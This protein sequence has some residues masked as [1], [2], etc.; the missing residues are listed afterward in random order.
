[1]VV[2]GESSAVQI[3]GAV[4]CCGW[5]GAA[6]RDHWIVGVRLRFYRRW[7]LGGV[8]VNR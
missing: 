5:K 4:M 8:G 1:M 2:A 6:I 7:Q 3:I